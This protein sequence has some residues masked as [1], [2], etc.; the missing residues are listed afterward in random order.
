L[1]IVYPEISEMQARAVFEAAAEV[2]KVVM[3]RSLADRIQ[4]ASE[5]GWINKQASRNYL[6]AHRLGC[7]NKP[8]LLGG[9]DDAHGSAI[10]D[11]LNPRTFPRGAIVQDSLE[12]ALPG[13][14]IQGPPFR[15]LPSPKRRWLER[16][17]HPLAPTSHATPRS[18]APA[19]SFAGPAWISATTDAGITSFSVRPTRRSMRPTLASRISGE[20][21]TPQLFLTGQSLGQF[22]D[23]LLNG[24]NAEAR[25]FVD[26][27]VAA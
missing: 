11:A 13:N 14:P 5:H 27:L 16:V 10:W 20:A 21:L 24:R 19:G 26:E 7:G 2:Q 4:R 22:L 18:H 23:C 9:K 3:L 8:L 17:A 12:L 6:V 15:P 25:Q 1:G